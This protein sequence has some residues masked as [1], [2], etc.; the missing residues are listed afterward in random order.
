MSTMNMDTVQNQLRRHAWA[1]PQNYVG[2]SPVGDYLIAARHRDS[3]LVTRSNWHCLARDFGAVDWSPSRDLYLCNEAPHGIEWDSRPCVYTWRARHFAVGWI[4]YM[5][6]RADASSDVLTRAADVLRRL[7]EYPIYSED[8]WSE[9]E[10]T[11]ACELWEQMPLAYR[12]AL[13]RDAGI[14]I[15]AA[16]RDHMPNFSA[17]NQLIRDKTT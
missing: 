5:M 8:H 16:R 2:F 14:S 6:L 1:T 3:D 10:Y 4:E 13:C 12:V 7:D 11:E 17:I 15:F 9:L